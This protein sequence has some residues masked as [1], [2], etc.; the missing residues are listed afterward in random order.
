MEIK[1]ERNNGKIYVKPEAK[2]LL[3]YETVDIWLTDMMTER[4]GS[5]KTKASYLNY[6]CNFV[7]WT[8]DH[9]KECRELHKQPGRKA[10]PDDIIK[11]AIDKLKADVMADWAERITKKWFTWMC[12]DGGLARTTAKT[13][14]GAI[15]SFFRCNRTKF[16]GKTPSATVRTR[17]IIPEKEK[18]QE[19]WKIADLFEKIRIGLLN[20]TGMRPEDTVSLSYKIIKDSFEKN[21]GYIYITDISEK[22]D[23]PYAVFLTRPT[24]RLMHTYFEFRVR[25]GETITGDSP[26]MTK[27]H[28]LGQYIGVNQLYRDITGLGKRI[29]IKISPKYFRKR[30][31]TECSPIIGKEATMKMAG[32]TL[33]GVGRHYF[34]PPKAQTLREY[35]KVELV[36]CLE[37]VATDLDIAAQRRMSAEMLRAAGMDPEGL[38]A[39]ADIGNSIKDQAD[40]LTKQLVG[41]LNI[42]KVVNNAHGN[43]IPETGPVSLV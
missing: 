29:G 25:E 5:E 35:K 24:T 11:I 12:S 16:I 34:L 19:M 27:R 3:K 14:Y 22:E 23:Q 43:D 6:F 15:R 26:I 31:R 38:L 40:F 28:H 30:F 33:P 32:W 8:K 13:R 4:T 37:D 1:V 41:L 39:K 42:V 10:I 36:I 18:L 7:E 20:D 21:E 9:V 2:E 17:Y